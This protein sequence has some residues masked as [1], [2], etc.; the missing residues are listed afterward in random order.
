MQLIFNLHVS[1]P[2]LKIFIQRYAISSLQILL[3]LQATKNLLL[4]AMVLRLLVFRVKNLKNKVETMI[5]I[6]QARISL[7]LRRKNLG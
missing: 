4:K 6:M 2:S 7:W 5:T 3:D 1:L